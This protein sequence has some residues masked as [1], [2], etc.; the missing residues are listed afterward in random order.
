MRVFFIDRVDAVGTLIIDFDASTNH[1]T[2]APAL[3]KLARAYDQQTC[4]EEDKVTNRLIAYINAHKD[5]KYK[6]EENDE[7]YM[8]AAEDELMGEMD[9]E[10]EVKCREAKEA[11]TAAAAAAKAVAKAAA[12][13][14]A[15]AKAA[16]K[17]AAAADAAEA[18]EAAEADA[19]EAESNAMIFASSLARSKVQRRAEEVR[20]KAKLHIKETRNRKQKNT[21]EAERGETVT[22]WR[23]IP[24]YSRATTMLYDNGT[25]SLREIV[26]RKFTIKVQNAFSEGDAWDVCVDATNY[27]YSMLANMTG[28]RIDGEE[29]SRINDVP[30]R[31]VLTS[32]EIQKIT[33]KTLLPWTVDLEQIEKK[34]K[35]QTYDKL[36]K[37]WWES[38]TPDFSTGPVTEVGQ[39]QGNGNNSRTNRQLRAADKRDRQAE[40]KKAFQDAKKAPKIR[41]E[42]FEPVK[43]LTVTRPE[44]VAGIK[45]N[46][47]WIQWIFLVP[48]TD[49][50]STS[51]DLGST[52]TDLGS[53]ST[54]LGSTSTDD[55]SIQNPPKVTIT[56]HKDSNELK[57]VAES[58]DL[59]ERCYRDIWR[60]FVEV[61]IF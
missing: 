20:K 11:A 25:S 42:I 24:T 61:A 10:K 51:T 18:A 19:A 45:Q 5:M 14:A 48:S 16:A 3:S 60:K 30:K 15:A 1:A 13:K 28:R 49:L 35:D 12:A 34:Y 59:I 8:D 53:T 27:L 43:C 31:V 58:R 44:A 23:F 40:A 50:G 41:R 21:E 36:R 55:K 29:F 22:S 9:N 7:S 33:A 4:K 32:F 52:S 56:I 39:I 57:L 54:D 47:Q 46:I 38:E 26:G 17:A 6:K 37:S 2:V